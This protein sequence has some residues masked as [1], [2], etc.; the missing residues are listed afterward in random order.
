MNLNVK[1]RSTMAL[2]LLLCL[3][4]I[5]TYH[6]TYGELFTALAEMEELLD[7]ESVLIANLENYVRPISMADFTI[8]I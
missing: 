5:V 4:S 7:T 8:R 2:S 1:S 6:P 3:A